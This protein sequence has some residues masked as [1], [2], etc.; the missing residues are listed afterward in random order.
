MAETVLT[1]GQR[2]RGVAAATGCISIV[3]L[4]SG[5]TWPLLALRLDAQGVDSRWVGLSASAQALSI[6]LVAPLAPRFVRRLG[7]IR[8]IAGCL[9]A[10]ATALL[11]L[12]LIPN[13]YAWF[14]IRFLLGAASST[15]FIIGETW[16]T[17]RPIVAC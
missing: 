13:L 8:S 16:I 1:A 15:I 9:A 5:L 17:I 10:A 6:M 11:L 2:W 3:G 7:I 4:M 12:P 14:P